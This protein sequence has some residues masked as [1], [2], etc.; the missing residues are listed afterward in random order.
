[1]DIGSPQVSTSRDWA[2][3]PAYPA[4]FLQVRYSSKILLYL[5][6]SKVRR[7]HRGTMRTPFTTRIFSRTDRHSWSC[8]QGARN[9]T[10]DGVPCPREK[11]HCRA[12]P[13][14]G[15]AVA[16]L[17]C[18]GQASREA[19]SPA[20][21]RH[22]GVRQSCE[23]AEVRAVTKVEAVSGRRA[24]PL[25]NPKSGNGAASGRMLAAKRAW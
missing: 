3:R 7:L 11:R 9:R 4:I 1:M 23:E 21:R 12:S 16:V 24:P 20:R 14:A 17:R 25:K 13:P 15:A 18:H 5:L 2:T 10:R 22:A 8:S 6:L 19:R